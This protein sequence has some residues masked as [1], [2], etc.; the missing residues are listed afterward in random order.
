MDHA[1]ESPS[2]YMTTISHYFCIKNKYFF[3][4]FQVKNLRKYAPKRTKL[5]NLKKIIGEACPSKRLLRGMQLAH[6]PK[7]LSSP[8]AKPT[9]AHGRLLRNVFEELHS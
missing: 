7:K 9:Y 2:K 8:L 5:H 1:P 6:P 3:Y 4:F